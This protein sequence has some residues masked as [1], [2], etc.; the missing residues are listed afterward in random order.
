[1]ARELLTVELPCCPQCG[2][3]SKLPAGIFSGQG[4]CAGPKGAPH[5]RVR[6]QPRK[7]VEVPAP[8]EAS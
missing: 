1:M 5:K 6:M 7:F 8:K 3:V 4:F 2:H